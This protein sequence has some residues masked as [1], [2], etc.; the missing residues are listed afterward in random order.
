MAAEFT[1]RETGVTPRIMQR[2]L[3]AIGRLVAW[4]M[5]YL[6]H[7]NMRPRHFTRD[8]ARMYGYADRQGEGSRANESKNYWTSYSGK[9]RRKMGHADPLKYTGESE[10][11]TR[12][13]NISS[14]ATS[15]RARAQVKMNAQKLNYKAATKSGIVIDKVKELT[16]ITEAETDTVIKFSKRETFERLKALKES[17]SINL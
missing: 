17:R 13:V 7:T 6:W 2:E 10:S 15:K 4:G 14:T 8:G 12:V 9:K 16:T 11:A 5:G 1:A 3:N